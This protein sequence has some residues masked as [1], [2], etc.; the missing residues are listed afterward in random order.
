MQEELKT[1]YR[2]LGPTMPRVRT[3]TQPPLDGEWPGLFISS[4]VSIIPNEL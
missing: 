3:L 1:E 2:K 4:R